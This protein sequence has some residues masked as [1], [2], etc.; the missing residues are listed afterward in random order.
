M[1]SKRPQVDWILISFHAMTATFRRPGR[2]AATAVGVALG[3]AVFL[4]TVGWSQTAGSQINQTFDE[5]AATI[6]TVRDTQGDIASDA[7]M[8]EDAQARLEAIEGV[9]AGGRIWEGPT[10]NVKVSDVAVEKQVSILVADAGAVTASAATLL[11]GRFFD[12]VPATGGSP[13]GVIGKSLAQDLGIADLQHDVALSLTESHVNVTIVGIL[14]SPGSSK[15]LDHALIVP[16]WAK[17]SRSG[18]EVTPIHAQQTG[19]VRVELGTAAQIANVVPYALRPTEPSRLGVLVPPEPAA[20]RDQVQGSLDSLAYGAAAL[21]LLIGGIGIMNSMLNAVSQRAGEI[22]LRRSM[23]A[24]KRHIVVQFLI[25][26]ALLGAIGS[27]AGL[28]VGE[29]ALLILSWI[30]GW[31]PVLSRALLLLAPIV[32]LSIGVLA[33]LYPAIR[34]ASIKPSETLRA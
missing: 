27:L 1:R 25:E 5:L 14:D 31:S 20:L 19:V 26:G 9:V 29:A 8:P 23:G 34:A 2:S 12:D 10:Q 21:S 30:N 33:S 15:E 3:I 32:G 24:G 22:G 18:T 13:V 11:A 28:L 6:L 16:T 17:I 7:P 4:V